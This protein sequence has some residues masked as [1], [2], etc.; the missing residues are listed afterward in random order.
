MY[1]V[2]KKDK[3]LNSI[4]VLDDSDNTVTLTT[5]DTFNNIMSNIFSLFDKP[6]VYDYNRLSCFAQK[7]LFYSCRYILEYNTSIDYISFLK[8]LG[9]VYS[10]NKYPPSYSEY[11]RYKN[12]IS[13]KRNIFKDKKYNGEFPLYDESVYDTYK[14]YKVASMSNELDKKSDLE[15]SENL[16]KLI[17]KCDDK[18]LKELAKEYNEFI[19]SKELNDKNFKEQRNILKIQR[20]NANCI[21]GIISKR[22]KLTGKSFSIINCDVYSVT[23]SYFVLDFVD[24]NKINE[25]RSEF[26]SD[27]YELLRNYI[28]RSK[29]NYIRNMNLDLYKVSNIVFRKNFNELRITISLKDSV[30]KLKEKLEKEKIDKYNDKHYIVNKNL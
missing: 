19:Q 28:S 3:S 30:V 10:Y 20:E 27:S 11:V 13:S 25:L 5:I 12:F 17:K 24:I 23:I 14:V 29:N 26:V 9:N 15:I 8:Y 18:R 16:R 21:D 1:I 6:Y 22:E 2:L 7:R 4:L